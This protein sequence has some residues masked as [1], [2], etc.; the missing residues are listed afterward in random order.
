MKLGECV[1]E[2]RLELK[3]VFTNQWKLDAIWK[4]SSNGI[5]PILQRHRLSHNQIWSW[6][7]L[8]W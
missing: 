3:I 5:E 6:F 4:C 2:L 1:D 8:G 7:K